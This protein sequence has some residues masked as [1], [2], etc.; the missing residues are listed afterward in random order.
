VYTDKPVY[1]RWWLWTIVGGGVLV[2]T[3][4]GLGVGLAPRTPSLPAGINT[5]EPSF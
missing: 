4:I 5:Y 2:I 3:G 1:K